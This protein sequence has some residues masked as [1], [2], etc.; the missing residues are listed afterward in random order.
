MTGGGKREGA[1]RILDAFAT[2]KKMRTRAILAGV[3][4]LVVSVGIA[5][6][7]RWEFALA[8]VLACSLLLQ[9]AYERMDTIVTASVA[10]GLKMMGWELTTELNEETLATVERISRGAR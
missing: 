5:V 9:Y 6:L 8:T 7:T 4:L 3:F 1:Q 10:N 2:Q